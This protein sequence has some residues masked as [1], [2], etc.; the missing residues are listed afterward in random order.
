MFI[1]F[2]MLAMGSKK[3]V[4]GKKVAKVTKNQKLLLLKCEW[5]R[6]GIPLQKKLKKDVGRFGSCQS[7]LGPCEGQV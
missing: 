2:E 4:K 1:G 3:V 7:N 6:E 5:R